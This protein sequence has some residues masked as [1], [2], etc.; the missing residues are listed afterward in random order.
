M[1]KPPERK[2]RDWTVAGLARYLNCSFTGPGDVV[3]KGVSGLENAGPEDLVFLSD[4]KQRHLLANTRA[5]AAVLSEEER[6]DRIP[7]IRS[8]TP[9]LTFIKAV[10][11]FHRPCLLR[12]GIHEQAFVSPTAHIGKDAAVGA[13]S[14]I[15]D[16][17]RIGEGT[18]IFPLVAVYPGVTVGNNCVVHSH[19]S[20][21]EKSQVGDRV[22][23]HNGVVIGAD[24][25]GYLQAEDSTHIKIPQTG[26]VIIEDDVEIGAN[27]TIDRAAL[28]RTVIKKGT[29]IDNLVQ[30]AHSVRIGEHNVLAGQTGIAGSSSTGDFVIMAGQVGIA[31]HVNV[32][33]R[34]IIAAK[35]GVTKDIPTGS[36]VA[37][38]PHKDIREWRKAWVSIP[39]LSDLTKAF[40]KL[41]K[42]VAELEKNIPPKE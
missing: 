19:V 8:G 12:P 20:I 25:F 36:F 41:Q 15:G 11:L 42:R 10:S 4:P 38:S 27:T 6:F 2:E 5:G 29:K 23:L 37:G 22:V 35:S 21:R 31:D 24:G 18:V 7:A 14:F 1:N 30:I 40:K 34:V 17:V 32:G 16:D 3:I 26:R 28:D 33:D 13:F 9:H 39:Q